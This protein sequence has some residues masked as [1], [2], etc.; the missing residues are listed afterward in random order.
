[1]SDAQLSFDEYVIDG[2]YGTA[3][4]VWVS[5]DEVL[6]LTSENLSIIYDNIYQPDGEFNSVVLDLPEAEYVSY[7]LVRRYLGKFLS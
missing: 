3:H 4:R 2:S 5:T 1:M 7:I 6:S